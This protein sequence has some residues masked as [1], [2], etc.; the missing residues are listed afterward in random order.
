MSLVDSIRMMSDLSLSLDLHVTAIM[1]GSVRS[2]P[3]SES[4]KD[5]FSCDTTFSWAIYNYRTPDT[6]TIKSVQ[7]NETERHGDLSR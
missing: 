4:F 2:F 3:F 7:T 5:E 1:R 6:K